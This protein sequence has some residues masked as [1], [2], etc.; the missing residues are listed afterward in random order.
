[1]VSFRAQR[2]RRPIRGVAV[3]LT[4]R[5]GK[6]V[7]RVKR[8]SD[9]GGLVRVRVSLAGPASVTAQAGAARAVARL[10]AL[11][12]DLALRALPTRPRAG[13]SLVV[14]GGSRAVVGRSVLVEALGRRGWAVVARTRADAAGRFQALVVVPAAGRYVIRARIGGTGGGVSRPLMVTAR[15]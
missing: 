10:A 9:R 3:R 6:A 11:R 13:Q 2:G 1:M 12:V 7:H 5:A 8:T 4:I 14:A 15:P